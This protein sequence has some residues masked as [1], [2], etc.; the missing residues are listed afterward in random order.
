MKEI[1]EAIRDFAL[2][3][4][5]TFITGS[6]PVRKIEGK[7][8]LTDYDG[9]NFEGITDTKTKHFYI[10]FTGRTNYDAQRRGANVQFYSAVSECRIVGVYANGDAEEIL[11]TLINS[12]TAKGHTVLRSNT[13]STTVFRE[14]T[15]KD[16][17]NKNLTLV[18]VDFNIT[19]L[20]SGRNCSLNPCDC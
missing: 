9:Q 12:V 16:L 14:E 6:A 15:G 1:L 17:T 11:T 18:S 5:T 8:I 3:K 10:R 4:Y 13:E 20:I 7:D 2:T 19:Q